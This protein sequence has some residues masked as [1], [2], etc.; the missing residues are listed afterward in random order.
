M[1]IVDSTRPPTTTLPIPRYISDPAPGK[2]TSGIMAITEVVVLMVMGR[3]L[4]RTES[5]KASPDLP[6]WSRLPHFEVGKTM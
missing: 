6:A 3:I 2:T 4:V 5:S 1:K